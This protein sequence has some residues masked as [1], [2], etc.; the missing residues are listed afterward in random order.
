MLNSALNSANRRKVVAATALI[1]QYESAISH[2]T[3]L[4]NKAREE[5]QSV[6]V[7]LDAIVYP[8]LT[9]PVEITAEIFLHCLTTSCAVDLNPWNTTRIPLL[10]TRI[11]R[12]WREIAISTPALWA[13]VKLKIADDARG[14]EIINTWSAR[15]G[16]LLQSIKQ[17]VDDTDS[18]DSDEDDSDEEDVPFV[19]RP[20]PMVFKALLAASDQIQCLDMPDIGVENLPELDGIA[21]GAY[22]FPALQ[23]L[24]IGFRM[25]DPLV[26]ES[27]E[28][29]DTPSVQVF[30]SAPLLHEAHLIGVPPLFTPLPWHQLTMFTGHLFSAHWCLEVLRLCPNLTES[31]FTSFANASDIIGVTTH[32][33]LKSL[34]ILGIRNACRVDILE[35][36]ALPALLSLHILDCRFGASH[37]SWLDAFLLR[38][39]TLR[40]C[41]LDPGVD[42]GR[43]DPD[44]FFSMSALTILELR[45]AGG[46]FLHVF[47]NHLGA[48]TNYL[49]ALQ[50][51]TVSNC[52]GRESQGV[53]QIIQPGLRARWNARYND[54]IAPLISFRLVLASYNYAS[55]SGELKEDALRP[56]KTLKAEGLNISMEISGYG[57]VSL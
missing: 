27:W 17:W 50:R 46:S 39:P 48:D 40:E 9:L 35:Y 3:S 45:R 1:S 25:D 47:F 2:Y 56:F 12:L 8:V 29:W 15:A 33:G 41:V 30:A 28:D 43:M 52:W 4:V 32:S 24:A 34:T 13:N 57:Q 20:L 26:H 22:N 21:A 7:E 23:K 14:A 6:Q 18:D 37:K 42:A 49:P 54:G 10:L 36:L 16:G 31:T 55:A 44:V 5:R 53:S 19:G 38:S 11:C 51:L